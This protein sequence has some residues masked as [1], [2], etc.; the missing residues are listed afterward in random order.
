MKLHFLPLAHDNMDL[1]LLHNQGFHR[2]LQFFK[3]CQCLSLHFVIKCVLNNRIRDKLCVQ[4]KINPFWTFFLVYF[5]Y[6]CYSCYF[7][8]EMKFLLFFLIFCYQ[9][10]CPGILKIYLPQFFSYT[11]LYCHISLLGPIYLQNTLLKRRFKN[12]LFI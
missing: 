5:C 9:M 12:T 11:H 4:Y 3:I 1:V 7:C 2:I 6:F 8:Y 10:K